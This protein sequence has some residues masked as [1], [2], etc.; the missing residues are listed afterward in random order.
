[1]AFTG[2][3]DLL[4]KA[5]NSLQQ[6]GKK[7]VV[8]DNLSSHLSLNVVK[9]CEEND[10]KFVCLPPNS[11]HLTQPLDIA[12]FRPLKAKWRDVLTKWKQ[13]EAGKK[14]ASLPKDQ[15][16]MLLRSV[17]DEI[18]PNLSKKLKGGFK[19]AG[20]FPR[21]K[22]EILCRLPKQDRSLNLDQV[23]DVEASLLLIFCLKKKKLPHLLVTSQK[24]EK[25][26]SNQKKIEGLPKITSGKKDL[27]DSTSEDDDAYSMRDS[28]ESD[29]VLSE[30]SVDEMHALTAEPSPSTSN[31]QASDSFSVS[32]P[33][34]LK[35]IEKDEVTLKS[36]MIDKGG[37]GDL[38]CCLFE[39][40]K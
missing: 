13:S 11:S 10:I 37:V 21:N 26:W 12:Y 28:G 16:P 19:K 35:D 36:S 30:D 5:S 15:F 14:V 7:V 39:N 2:G 29:L 8:G 33:N 24:N 34:P 20:V 31:Y 4:L 18:Q 38:T 25:R 23:G 1:M 22:D 3:I 27:H 40:F 9:L 6:S 17:L 32:T